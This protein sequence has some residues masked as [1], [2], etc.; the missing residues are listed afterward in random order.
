M[1]PWGALVALAVVAYGGALV[2][3]WR[4]RKRVVDD[5]LTRAAAALRDVHDHVEIPPFH[6]VMPDAVFHDAVAEGWVA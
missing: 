6:I 2:D 4:D 5:R 3:W 1:N